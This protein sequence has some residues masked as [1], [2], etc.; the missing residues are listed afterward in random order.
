MHRYRILAAVLLLGTTSAHASDEA[1][2]WKLIGGMLGLVQQIV[3]QAATSPDA[4]AAQKSVDALLA[5][6]NA[7]ANRIAS[8]LIDD[9]LEDVPAEQRGLFLAIGRDLATLARRERARDA[10]APRP[11]EGD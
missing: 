2:D 1:D 3:H 7:Q 6:Q 11:T 10:A 8:N 5:G 9:M 4:A